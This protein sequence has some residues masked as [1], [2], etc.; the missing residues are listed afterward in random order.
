MWMQRNMQLL[1]DHNTLTKSNLLANINTFI[2]SDWERACKWAKNRF[3][4]KLNL[5]TLDKV[6]R[7]LQ[8]FSALG[9]KELEFTN[10][11]SLLATLLATQFSGGEFSTY[12]K[13][14][15]EAL[16]QQ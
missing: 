5:N 8:D 12:G 6:K 10:R 16:T 3:K 15:A 11:L 4:L 9:L 13:G 2:E 1:R 14:S 7:Q